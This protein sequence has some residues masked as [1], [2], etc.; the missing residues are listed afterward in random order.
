MLPAGF[1]P[2]ITACER[3][4]TRALDRATSGFGARK[5]YCFY[6]NTRIRLDATIT[7]Y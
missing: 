2:T 3:P 1:Q 4:Q 6:N 7:V 5:I